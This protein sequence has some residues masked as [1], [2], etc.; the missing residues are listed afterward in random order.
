MVHDILT[1]DSQELKKVV[2]SI[3]HKS[4]L[5]I[6]TILDTLAMV[7]GVYFGVLDWKSI[8]SVHPWTLNH[9]INFPSLWRG[10][11]G[12]SSASPWLPA[13]PH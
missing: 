5:N 2:S 3:I 7:P 12:L 6:A 4:V 8:F 11:M 1:V 9:K 13:Q 10:K